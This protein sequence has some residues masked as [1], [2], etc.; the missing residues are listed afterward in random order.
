MAVRLMKEGGETLWG[1]GGLFS[2][3]VSIP[4]V[5]KAGI[6]TCRM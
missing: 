3:L 1:G 4:N 2:R 6:I 5:E